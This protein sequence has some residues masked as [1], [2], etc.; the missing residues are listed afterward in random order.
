MPTGQ[1]ANNPRGQPWLAAHINKPHRKEA[2][3][4]SAKG[5]LLKRSLHQE[6]VQQEQE[7]EARIEA[8]TN[9]QIEKLEDVVSNERKERVSQLLIN[10]LGKGMHTSVPAWTGNPPSRVYLVDTWKLIQPN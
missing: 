8:R 1:G 4:N 5:E 6:T 3:A 2:M 7:R 9:E 10:L